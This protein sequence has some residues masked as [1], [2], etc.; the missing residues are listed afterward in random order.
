MTFFGKPTAMK[1]FCFV[2]LAL[3]CAP[4]RASDVTVRDTTD[5][6]NDIYSG[7]FARLFCKGT[8]VDSFETAFGLHA[9]GRDSLVY[10]K[11]KTFDGPQLTGTYFT[12][13]MIFTPKGSAA[14]GDS[15]LFYNGH[16]SSPACIDS[17]LYYWGFHEDNVYAVRFDIAAAQTDTMPFALKGTVITDSPFH[18]QRPRLE[19]KGVIFEVKGGQTFVAD[20]DMKSVRELIPEKVLSPKAPENR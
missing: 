19:G 17:N 18:F 8:L 13:L 7:R 1:V 9:V 6:V 11:V 5:Y 15:L 4:A 16:F 14:L 10:Q 20:P 12:T 3:V 2:L